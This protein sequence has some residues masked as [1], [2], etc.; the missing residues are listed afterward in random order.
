MN[1]RPWRVGLSL[2]LAVAPLTWAVV[3]LIE[4]YTR[5]EPDPVVV[6]WAERSHFLDRALVTAYV[7][8]ALAMLL[9]ALARRARGLRGERSWHAAL[10]LGALGAALRVFA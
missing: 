6:V 8:L 10:T 5:P 3:G 2:A 7:T 4:R 9:A 1:P